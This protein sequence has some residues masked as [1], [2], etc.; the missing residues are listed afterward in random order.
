VSSAMRQRLFDVL[1][2]CQAF[3]QYLVRLGV[4]DQR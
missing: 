1:E 4:A 2:S 3:S